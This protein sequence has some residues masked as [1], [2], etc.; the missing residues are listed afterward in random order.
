MFTLTANE[1]LS[2]SSASW[3]FLQ[4]PPKSFL[5]RRRRLPTVPLVPKQT[6]LHY[7]SLRLLRLHLIDRSKWG[8]ADIDGGGLAKTLSANKTNMCHWTTTDGQNIPLPLLFLRGAPEWRVGGDEDEAAA[9]L[10]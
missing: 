7:N 3:S 5:H 6:I 8:M 4:M 10:A 1:L 2:I 9:L